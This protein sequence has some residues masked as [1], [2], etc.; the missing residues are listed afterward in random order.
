MH[1][2]NTITKRMRSIAAIVALCP[3]LMLTGCNKDAASIAVIGG[4]D[5]PTAIY[6]TSKIPGGQTTVLLVLLVALVLAIGLIS[7]WR[8]NKHK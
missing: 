4:A 8:Q 1:R 6:L 5:G 2:F 3:A 7:W